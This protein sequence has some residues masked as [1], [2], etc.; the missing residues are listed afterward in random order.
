MINPKNTQ[1]TTTPTN[2]GVSVQP[3]A[4][5]VVQTYTFEQYQAGMSPPPVNN[6]VQPQMPAAPISTPASTP[7]LAT[8][9]LENGGP[10][11]GA[12]VSEVLTPWQVLF[13]SIEEPVLP[14]YVPN[15]PSATPQIVEPQITPTPSV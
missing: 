14:E 3:V 11:P 1:T 8:P 9:P 7:T 5:P 10:L 2:T 15:T 13:W 12:E 4:Q 6:I